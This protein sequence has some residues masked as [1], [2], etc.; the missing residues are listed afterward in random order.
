MQSSIQDLNE[1]VSRVKPRYGS[2]SLVAVPSQVRH[3]CVKAD[4]RVSAMR[5]QIYIVEA[6]RANQVSSFQSQIKR[7]GRHPIHV[8]NSREEKAQSHAILKVNLRLVF[9]R[10]SIVEGERFLIKR[11]NLSFASLSPLI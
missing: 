11:R 5:K 7:T 2:I 8:L 1:R 4:R 10:I 9:R 6:V 3:T